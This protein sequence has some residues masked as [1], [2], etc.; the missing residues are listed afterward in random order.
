MDVED[1]HKCLQGNICRCTGYRPIVE[2]MKKCLEQK[3]LLIPKTR[4]Q[5]E[6]MPTFLKNQFDEN[7]G[8]IPNNLQ[9]VLETTKK[10]PNYIFVQG[11]T[12]KYQ[13]MADQ[14]KKNTNI[15]RF[16]IYL[17][18]IQELKSAKIDPQTGN[19]HI[20]SG[21]KLVEMEEFLK[22]KN[23]KFCQPFL[24]AFGT[25][26][27]PQIR[28]V[29]TIGGSIL[30]RHSSSDLWPLYLIYECQIKILDL[31]NE[32]ESVISA[33]NIFEYQDRDCLI[34]ELIIP[35][36]RD[37]DIVGKF[38]KK[39]RRSEFDLAILNMGILAKF[40]GNRIEF[41]K[42]AF[43]GSDNLLEVQSHDSN[44]ISPSLA[45]N[46]MNYLRNQNSSEN[47]SCEELMNKIKIDL[48]G[49]NDQEKI[50][51][52]V[53]TKHR[54]SIALHFLKDFLTSFSKQNQANLKTDYKKYKSF[55]SM[56][57]YQE[58][59]KCL[60]N[61]Q[62]YQSVPHIWGQDLASGKAKFISDLPT[63]EAELEL[64]LIRSTKS[65]AKI[66]TLDF[67]EA[68]QMKGIVG[69]L[70]AKD[71]PESRNWWGLAIQDEEIFASEIV[72]YHGQV[73]GCIACTDPALGLK[74]LA[75]IKIEYENL[76]PVINLNHAMKILNQDLDSLEMIGEEQ[77]FERIQNPEELKDPNN[78]LVE[79][80]GTLR[81]GGAEHFYMET[82]SVKVVPM[83]EK[84]EYI[85]YVS[86]Q[87]VTPVQAKIAKVLNIPMHKII[88]KNKRLGGGFGG[89]E[90][91]HGALIGSLAAMKFQRPVSLV[92]TRAEDMEISGQKHEAVLRYQVK[93]NSKT[94]KLA[95]CNFKTY[96]NA[97]CS[98]DLSPFWAHILMLRIG[99][100]YT[101]KNFQGSTKVIKTNSPSNTSF[102]GFGGPEGTFFIETIMDRIA[103]E[104]KMSPKDV[105]LANLTADNDLLHHSVT[106][107]KGCTLQK[108][109]D[110]CYEKSDFETKMQ[111][112]ADFNSQSKIIKRGLSI[113]PLKFEPGMGAKDVMKGSAYI[114][115]Y[116][117]GSILL[118]HGGIEMGQGLHTKMIQ[119]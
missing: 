23:V 33:Q 68:L 82:N 119:V 55:K 67:N 34:L 37:S 94:G 87:E 51:K 13:M 110:T 117:D 85:V 64:I 93:V 81:I 20:G 15:S 32:T 29:A 90:R 1:I 5:I 47:I 77:T 39:A 42:I 62:V 30:W 6:V 108:C 60:K 86:S 74:A 17:G 83:I 63:Y 111:E 71:L 8:F 80:T 36:P 65:H 106:R 16:E 95:S 57:I 44:N 112:I 79:M 31:K 49:E 21:L 38:Y 102:R 100:G 98:A 72:W 99:G 41:I 45:K 56:Q 66:K 116:K 25:L 109:W 24:E 46:T 104:L 78:S 50:S 73:I 76:P 75:K 27:S 53:R 14:K 22:M 61:G 70:T 48:Y 2:G 7:F 35:N 26:A 69:C 4:I 10:N 105:K 12:G 28:N 103:H 91:M 54:I 11:G 18:Q 88:V 101:L 43:G 115:V 9:Q 52:N 114:R 84:E 92:L 97:G 107:I 3:N 19:V 40:I 118:T 89:K 58:D 113:V 59:E 96:V